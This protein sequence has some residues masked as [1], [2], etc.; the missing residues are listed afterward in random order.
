MTPFV[1][2]YLRS[3]ITDYGV[4]PPRET[5]MMTTRMT[6]RTSR[7]RKLSRRSCANRM[8]SKTF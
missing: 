6:T 3:L 1:R 5:M 8:K 7:R 4:M 2:Q